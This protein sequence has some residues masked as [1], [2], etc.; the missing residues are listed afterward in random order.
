MTEANRGQ[1]PEKKRK[2]TTKSI[3]ETDLGP[4]EA[5]I[6]QKKRATITVNNRL[7]VKLKAPAFYSRRDMTAFVNQ[8]AAWI[9]KARERFRKRQEDKSPEQKREIE[10]VK[11]GL[12]KGEKVPSRSELKKAAASYFLPLIEREAAGMGVTYDGV[13][14]RFQKTLWGSCSAKG[15]INLNA[16]LMM[17][18]ENVRRYVVVHE[19]AHRLEMNHS[20]R[21]WDHVGRTMPDWPYARRWLK[22]HGDALIL[23]ESRLP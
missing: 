18:P 22:E 12:W 2:A 20:K 1:V 15:H 14:I 11:E 19:L 9:E 13:T 5:T 6:W 16:M 4:V 10:E 7:E 8:N 17:A 3:L 23:L 21:F